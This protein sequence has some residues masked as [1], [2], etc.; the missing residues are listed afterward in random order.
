V[1]AVSTS[2]NFYR[3][4]LG[5]VAIFAMI[6]GASAQSAADN[7]R[8]V[9]QVCLAGQACVGQPARATG[10]SSMETQSEATEAQEAESPAPAPQAAV[11]EEPA[12]EVAAVDSDFDVE[13]QYQMSCFACHATGAAG[14]P[15]LGDAEAWN[16]RL[17]KGMDAVMANV[18]NGVNAM[19]AKG[20]CMDCSD[21]NLRALVDYMVSQ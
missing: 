6:S 15:L 9:S 1:R 18:V 8:P 13:A 11:V 21:D 10:P 3:L 19:P 5:I 14:A 20:L 2:A 16:T 17:E 4:I 7:I 12:T